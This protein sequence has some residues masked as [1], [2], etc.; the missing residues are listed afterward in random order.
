MSNSRF[1]VG[2]SV[3]LLEIPRE[4]F[5]RIVNESTLPRDLAHGG[6]FR[7]SPYRAWARLFGIRSKI[8]DCNWVNDP[9]WIVVEDPLPNGRW[10]GWPV[11]YVRGNLES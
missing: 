4:K 2:S 7:A 3:E 9:N 10:I 5:L 11:E 6:R 1:E 8:V